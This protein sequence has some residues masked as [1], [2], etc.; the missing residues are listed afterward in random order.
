[1]NDDGRTR[2]HNNMSNNKDRSLRPG[3][4]NF[5]RGEKND[6]RST[7]N[8]NNNNHSN[9]MSSNN[10]NNSNNRKHHHSHQQQQHDRLNGND[11]LSRLRKDRKSFSTLFTFHVTDIYPYKKIV[12]RVPLYLIIQQ[13]QHVA[14]QHPIEF[15]SGWIT[16][17]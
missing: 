7:H 2:D 13:H 14:H 6:R 8:N 17:L 1:M 11:N 16:A 5:M 9:P 3:E 10:N 4:R 15:Q 12:Q